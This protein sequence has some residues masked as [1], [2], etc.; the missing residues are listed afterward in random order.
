MTDDQKPMVLVDA[1]LRDA[2][3]QALI[4]TQHFSDTKTQTNAILDLLTAAA[5]ALPVDET[6]ERIAACPTPVYHE[7]HRY[8]PSCPWTER[9]DDA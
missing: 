8:C 9:D 6:Q 5:R 3:E 4:A 7:T 2:I 1:N